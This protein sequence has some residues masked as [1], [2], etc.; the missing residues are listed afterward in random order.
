MTESCIYLRNQNA[1]VI[2]EKNGPAKLTTV[3]KWTPGPGE[4]LIK[5]VAIATNP[6]DYK[7]QQ[8]G[9]FVTFPAIVGSD[10]AGV[11]EE[12]GEGVTKFKKG[13]EVS[14]HAKNS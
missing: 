3:E 13:D 2:P 9:M 5:N 4:I 1:A 14:C 12:V 10:V 8:T 7:I 6:V 11:V